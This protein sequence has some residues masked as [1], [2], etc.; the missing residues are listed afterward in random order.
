MAFVVRGKQRERKT[1]HKE[2]STL[3]KTSKEANSKPPSIDIQGRLPHTRKDELSDTSRSL[4]LIWREISG[5]KIFFI[6]SAVLQLCNVP[7][8]SRPVGV[9][10]RSHSVALLKRGKIGKLL[11]DVPKRLFKQKG[12]SKRFE[13][14]WLTSLCFDLRCK[15]TNEAVESCLTKKDPELHLKNKGIHKYFQDIYVIQLL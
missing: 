4:L 8:L 5:F 2:N 3:K 15:T 7:F 13:D 14:R 1:K 10:S 6:W 9:L 11:Y 12:I